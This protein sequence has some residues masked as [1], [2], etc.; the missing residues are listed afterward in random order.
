[1]PHERKPSA[2]TRKSD[3]LRVAP[4]SQAELFERHVRLTEETFRVMHQ[5]QMLLGGRLVELAELTKQL[6]EYAVSLQSQIDKLK[7]TQSV[8]KESA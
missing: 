1:M 7:G 4:P 5:Q 2:A 6:A 3:R 8:K